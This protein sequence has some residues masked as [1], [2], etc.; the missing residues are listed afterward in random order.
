[1]SKQV[2]KVAAREKRRMVASAVG[3]NF[4]KTVTEPLTNSDSI[5]KKQAGLSHAAGLVSELLSIEP[6]QRL[7]SSALKVRI[8]K[9]KV[10]KIVLE[11]TTAGP[12]A[13]LCRV[14]DAGPGMT[15]TELRRNFGSY[16]EAKAKGEGTRSLF[17]RGALD[18]LLYHDES[19]IFSVANGLLSLCSI[20]WQDDAMIDVKELGSA[21]KAL[22]NEHNLP[23]I[24]SKSGTVVQFR[25]KEKTSI[26]NEDQIVAKISDFYMLRLIAA[27]PNTEVV[28]KRMRADGEHADRLSYDFPTGTVLGKFADILDLGSDGSLNVD[29]LVARSDEPLQS[30][31]VHIDRREN[32]LLFVDENDAVM[33]LTLLPEYDKNPYLHH[34]FGIVRITGIRAVLESKLE[35]DEAFAVLKE[36][37]DGFDAKR[38]ITQRLFGLVEKHVKP[39]YEKEI[40]RQRKGSNDRSEKLSQRV[41]DVLKAINQF[42]NEETDEEGTQNPAPGRDEAIFFD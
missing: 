33:D 5:L 24:L 18:V 7:D 37:R 4:L 28:V 1:M 27:D 41:K 13:R 23:Q 36:T 32:G 19:Q 25:L 26:P 6:G 42:N 8:P 31:P 16:A 15:A 9:Q 14:L 21:T 40:Q 29:L 22:L 34:I 10:R 35:S 3:R 12:E 11:V 38:E 2:I 30:D 17:G 39:I 20:Y